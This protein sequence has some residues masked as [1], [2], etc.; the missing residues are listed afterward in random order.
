MSYISIRSSLVVAALRLNGLGIVCGS[1]FGR[2][3]YWRVGG[4]GGEAFSQR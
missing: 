2:V 3:C 4:P 1:E